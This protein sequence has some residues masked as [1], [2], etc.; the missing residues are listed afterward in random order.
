MWNKSRPAQGIPQ[1]RVHCAGGPGGGGVPP[2]VLTGISP[3]V[4][5]ALCGSKPC[6]VLPA[7]P[8]ACRSKSFG[9]IVQGS[10]LVRSGFIYAYDLDDLG[11]QVMFKVIAPGDR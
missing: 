10:F 2:A 9:T 1:W 11:A 8:A 6:C 4:P 3:W 5:P 7:L